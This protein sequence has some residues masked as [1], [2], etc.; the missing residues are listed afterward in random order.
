[1]RCNFCSKSF[2]DS[3]SCEDHEKTVHNKIQLYTCKICH[4]KNRGIDSFDKHLTFTHKT[5]HWH[6]NLA[7]KQTMRDMAS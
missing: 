1:M 4:E 7:L 5:N 3:F 6:I 2:E